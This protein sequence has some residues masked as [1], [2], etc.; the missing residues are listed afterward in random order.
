MQR[1]VDDVATTLSLSL[2]EKN[3]IQSQ[4]ESMFKDEAYKESVAE[5][6][7]SLEQAGFIGTA[8]LLRL[9]QVVDR[10]A[11]SS[12]EKEAGG[13]NIRQLAFLVSEDIVSEQEAEEIEKSLTYGRLMDGEEL[14][15]NDFA[16]GRLREW[17]SALANRVSQEPEAEKFDVRVSGF[18]DALKRMNADGE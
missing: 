12:E 1:H 9:V 17:L 16:D 8:R 13:D 11:L 7:R 4:M 3:E 5:T 2:E 10:S 15:K 18:L 14:S 6:R